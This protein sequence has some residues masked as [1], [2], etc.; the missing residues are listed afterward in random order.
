MKRIFSSIFG[1]MHHK[2][3]KEVKYLYLKEKLEIINNI[4]VF[5][6]IV[7]GE[8]ED[9]NEDFYLHHHEDAKYIPVW[10]SQETVKDYLEFNQISEPFRIVQKTLEEVGILSR[11]LNYCSVR[12]DL[13]N[14]DPEPNNPFLKLRFL[15]PNQSMFS[16]CNF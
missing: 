10:T 14:K 5:S 7:L 15:S 13:K 9:K 3:V 4:K 11:T 16:F 6:I 12:F 8:E 2:D 1:K